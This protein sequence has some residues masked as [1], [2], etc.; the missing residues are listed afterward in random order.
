MRHPILPVLLCLAVGG[1]VGCK[2]GGSMS[3]EGVEAGRWGDLD[4]DRVQR[5]TL[6]NGNGMEVDLCDYG[7]MVTSVRVP[8]RNGISVDVVL[9]F[10]SIEEYLQKSQY[11]GC[12]VGRVGNRIAGGSFELDGETYLLAVN[13]GPN[14]LHGGERGFD[15]HIWTATQILTSRGAGIRFTRVSPAGEEGYPGT[16]EAEAIYILTEND[17]LVIEMSATTDA[18]TPCNIVHHTY[19]N[20][21]G[22]GSGTV[23]DETLLIDADRYT[24]VDAT[25]IPTGELAF[26]DG[27]PL[28][29]RAGKSIGSDFGAFP[30]DG[31]DPGGFDHNLCLNGEVGTIREVA[32]LSDPTTGI[33][34]TISTDQPGIQFYTGN[35]LNGMT[36]KGGAVYEKNG[37]LCLET[38]AFPDSIHQRG[39]LGWSDVV[40]KPGT[41]YGHVM[42]HR[43][44]TD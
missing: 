30:P 23:L 33:V 34:M 15:K 36:G 3:S 14:H 9:G 43:F 39:E 27:T 31:D 8:D 40:L 29:F 32:R 42:V 28:D 35:F 21:G 6:R 44:T 16:L 26:V 19:W 13:N 1:F 18:A 22:H 7:A 24:P 25:L 4:G 10:D 17:E 2:G 5:F 41:S 12:T 11:F 38:Q 37:A 20:L